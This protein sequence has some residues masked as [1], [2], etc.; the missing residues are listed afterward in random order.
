MKILRFMIIAA[1]FFQLNPVLISG[2][3]DMNALKL[4]SFFT[5]H[6]V[7]QRNVVF[8]VYGEAGP[9][10][11]VKVEFAGRSADTKADNKGKW[12]A[13]LQP[14]NAGG[15]YEI[16]VSSGGALVV[17]KDVLVGDVWFCSGQSNM[18]WS[19]LNSDDG[20]QELKKITVKPNIR[21]FQQAQIPAPKPLAEPAG[22]WT[23]CERGSL[24]FF[25]AVA[26]YYGLKLNEELNVPIGLIN[27]S[28]GGT[29][30]EIWMDSNVL[31]SS[32][33][34]ASILE[35]WKNNPV[36]DWKTWNDGKGMNYELEISELKFYS[37]GKKTEPL[38]VK[39]SGESEGMLGGHWQAWAKPGSV[40]NVSTKGKSGMI[41]GIIGF[42]AWAGAGTLLNDGA[43]FDLSKYDELSFKVRGN[44]KFSLSLCQDSIDDY[45]Y[46]STADYEAGRQWQEIK[47]PIAALKQAG[48]GRAKKFTP[49]A[50]KQIQFNIKSI[51][52]ELPSALYNGMVEP[53][54]KFPITGVIWYQGESNAGRAHQY[55]KLLP[56][57]I[58]NWRDIWKIGDF[59]FLVVQLPNYMER[60]TEPSESEWAELREAQLMAL[61]L[62]NTAVVSTIDLGDPNDVH[63]RV[64]KPVG[65]RL[66]QAALN[67]AY[68][69]DVVPMGPVY[70]S[71]KLDGNRVEVSFK[72]VGKGLKS[73]EQ[74]LKG[75]TVAG[76]DRKF[77]N[78]K[79]E[80]KGE[81]VYVWNDGI[82]EPAAVRYA[83]ADNPECGL[84]SRDGL[85]ASPFRTDDWPGLTKGRF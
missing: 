71:M 53:F 34:T 14:L 9:G 28:W 43:D 64:K 25:S 18:E 36:F 31:K 7:I 49:E 65:D 42:N 51:T 85:A 66:A 6:M 22:K 69:K 39:F 41:S 30:I 58:N 16:K 27:S 74:E 17:L 81:K 62:P 54:A 11:D 68:G 72:Y 52:V 4:N 77:V 15:P 46:Y 19:M 33:E 32:A 24:Q 10:A 82:K 48:W 8:N 12:R 1:V 75:F 79:A 56:M 35:R 70:H 40:A 13:E 23:V 45:D 20:A 21:L 78:A 80:I 50:I 2:R 83:W 60:K 44:A 55:R 5:D 67:I 38:A 26:Y 3:T 61:N 84:Y 57:M 76:A 73:K 29:P 47:V 37:S 59:P 63:P